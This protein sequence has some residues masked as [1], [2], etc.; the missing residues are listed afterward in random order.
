[1]YR[2][3]V[4]S[5]GVTQSSDPEVLTAVVHSVQPLQIDSTEIQ[6]LPNDGVKLRDLGCDGGDTSILVK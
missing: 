5:G 2:S 6:A 4:R 3:P 1:M